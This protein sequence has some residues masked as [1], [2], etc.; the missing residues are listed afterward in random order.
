MKAQVRVAHACSAILGS[1]GLY[2]TPNIHFDA[3]TRL[4]MKLYSY[5]SKLFLSMWTKRKDHITMKALIAFIFLHYLFTE[6]EFLG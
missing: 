6:Q 1:F 3:L 2:Q 5:I 4:S